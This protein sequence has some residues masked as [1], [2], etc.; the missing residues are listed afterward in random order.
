[1]N[2]IFEPYVVAY[3]DILGFS[4]FIEDAEKE[5]SIRELL[6]DLLYRVLPKHTQSHEINKQF[7][8]EKLKLQCLS[9]SDSIVISA[10]I[11]TEISFS[12]PSLIAVSIK[13]I[14]IAHALLGMGLLVRGAL[15]VGNVHRSDMNIVGTGYQHAVMGERDANYPKILFTDSAERH[16]GELLANSMTR[17]AIFSRDENS[18]I[19][20]NSLYPNEYYVD[21]RSKPVKDY[22]TAYRNTV[23]KNLNDPKL[24][25][26]RKDKWCWLAALFTSNVRYFS[27]LRKIPPIETTLAMS[28]IVPNCLNPPEDDTK[29]LDDFTLHGFTC[30]LEEPGV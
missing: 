5:E 19:I 13:S 8:S 20:L 25:D 30:T 14:Q 27:E 21:N 29:W 12:Y 15:S 23:L 3:L 11:S 7:P 26:R 10:P 1:M 2:L 22:Y 4:N 6:N 17:F 9:V 24:D 16:L 28:E 18:K